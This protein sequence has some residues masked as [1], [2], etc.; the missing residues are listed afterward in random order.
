MALT[1][2]FFV[3][4]AHSEH[5]GMAL[6]WF[7]VPCFK[8]LAAGLLPFGQLC[9]AIYGVS[10]GVNGAREARVLA[11]DRRLLVQSAALSRVFSFSFFLFSFFLAQDGPRTPQQQMKVSD[12]CVCI[13]YLI[14]IC[15]CVHT[16]SSLQCSRCC[17]DSRRT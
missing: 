14:Y 16:R 15:V 6:Q 11:D 17:S 2:F 1:D 3:R 5:K 4:A 12:V 10:V 8:R 7:L 13:K 9:M